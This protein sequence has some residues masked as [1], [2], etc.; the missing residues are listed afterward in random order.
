MAPQ[1]RLQEPSILA[2]ALPYTPRRLSHFINAYPAKCLAFA[3]EVVNFYM[4][5]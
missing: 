4:I 3:G 1:K 2:G 5:E